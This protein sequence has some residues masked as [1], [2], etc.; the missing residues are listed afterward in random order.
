MEIEFREHDSLTVAQNPRI[1]RLGNQ[2]IIK[3]NEKN[4]DYFL[5]LERTPGGYTD[6]SNLSIQQEILNIRDLFPNVTN[7]SLAD[8][9]TL[10][11]ID[12]VDYKI[13]D[14]GGDSICI[15][16]KIAEFT[17]V[18][19]REENGKFVICIPDDEI[20]CT[21][22]VSLTATYRI[23]QVN[24][25]IVHRS[26]GKD[27]RQQS[28]YVVEFEDIPNYQDG[29]IVFKFEGN[30]LEYPITEGMIEKGRIFIETGYGIPIFLTK[31]AGLEIQ[32]A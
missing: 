12:E 30:D 24:G 1:E 31:V 28:F 3:L 5:V 32:Q 19:C 18:G 7:V 4:C 22:R 11:C 20:S 10:S 9:V 26:F 8:G 2:R 25:D 21:A 29:G 23:S 13:N 6:L 15:P 17:V 14:Y 16:N 27:V